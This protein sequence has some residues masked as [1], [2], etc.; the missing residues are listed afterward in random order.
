WSD[1]L[2]ALKEWVRA[3]PDSVTARIALANS[4]VSYAWDARG[5]GYSDNVT[6][7][8]WN[9][10]DE[11]LRK[12]KDILDE[13]KT[14]PEKCPEW[15]LAKQNI[16]QGQGWGEE[17]ETSLLQEAI[18]FE[19]EYYSYYRVHAILL[20][21]KWYGAEGDA[22]KFA[23]AVADHMGGR[24][25]D[26]LYFQIAAKLVC[27]CEEPEYN[28]MSS[29]RIQRGFAAV[30]DTYGTSATNLNIFALMG[31]NFNDFVVADAAFKRI[32]ESWDENAWRTREYF[33]ARRNDGENRADASS[34]T[35]D[36]SRSNCQSAVS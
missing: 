16:R 17:K 30:E 8:G 33:E 5:K 32:G 7:S 9:L 15:Y 21:P 19:P 35:P 3:E 10:F 11:R 25:G 2:V 28:R 34:F 24:K 31:V 6:K 23:T 12:A 20:L 36:D 22:A 1:H 18:A 29:E 14:L 13:A 27:A 26:I 4:Y